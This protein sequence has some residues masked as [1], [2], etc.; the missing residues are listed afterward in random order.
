MNSLAYLHNFATNIFSVN[1]PVQM[2]NVFTPCRNYLGWL[3]MPDEH[4]YEKVVI[5]GIE[6]SCIKDIT[7]GIVHLF[8][9]ILAK[10]VSAVLVDINTG[11]PLDYVWTDWAISLNMGNS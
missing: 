5:S 4:E 11:T 6:L 2:T 10:K 8:D 9:G 1:F 3:Y 7:L